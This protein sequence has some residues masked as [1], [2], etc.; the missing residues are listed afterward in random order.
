MDYMATGLDGIIWALALA[1]QRVNNRLS[2]GR[3]GN[4]EEIE[5]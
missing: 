2:S 3:N 5:N 4:L 1:V